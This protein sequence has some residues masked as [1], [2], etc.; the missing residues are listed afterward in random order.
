MDLQLLNSC[1]KQ[2]LIAIIVQQFEHLSRLEAENL[3]LRG[4]LK[5]LQEQVKSLQA[6]LSRNS[7]NSSQPPS[8]DGYGKPQPKSQREKS[9][10]AS[11]GQPGHP[12][13]T[14]KQVEHPDQVECCPPVEVCSC[15]ADLSHAA[16]IEWERRQVFDLPQVRPQVTEYRAEVKVCGHCGK[17]VRGVFPDQVSQPVQYG[18]RVN[19]TVSYLSQYQLLPYERLAELLKDLFSLELSEGTIEN[20]LKRGSDKLED[21]DRAVKDRIAEDGLANFDE[22]GMRV[23]KTLH[24]LH[25][26]STETLTAYHIDRKRGEPAMRRMGILPRFSGRAVHDH[27]ASYFKFRCEHIL[28]N[29]HH[30][31]ELTFAEE[32]Y[33]QDWAKR[34]KECLLEA[35]KE[36]DAA[37]A[38][39]K[40][41]LPRQRQAYFSH[42]YSRILRAGRA[43]LPV[44]APSRGPKKRG[45]IKQHKVKN[46]HDRLCQYK[47]ET[48]AYVHDFST[49]FTNNQGERDVRM[50]KVKQKVSGCF[51]SMQG[52]K[53]FA[54]LRG[55]LS[56]A[57]KQG[58]NLIDAMTLL[59][60]DHEALTRRLTEPIGSKS[61]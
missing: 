58:L 12:G 49:P 20:T 28:C 55:A 10:R 17:T 7:R 60:E 50:A 14:L 27:W 51:R 43:E 56:T 34:L 40:K 29:A 30:L 18:P 4:Q 16:V 54:R 11:G 26:A 3:D 23:E 24:W 36:V 41:S 22:T 2:E 8:S 45:R 37:K 42:R 25:V 46:L 44:V 31:R 39:G 48:L 35:L 6:Q 57:K 13:Q 19:A 32:Q 1:T 61:A 21:F 59:F 15:G 5:S 38:A 47:R 52:A 9:E 33:R 53:I